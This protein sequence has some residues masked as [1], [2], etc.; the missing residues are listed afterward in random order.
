MR[1]IFDIPYVDGGAVAQRLDMYL[2][3]GEG[4]PTL[5]FFHGG[6]FEKCDKGGKEF[7]VLAEYFNSVGIG[8]ISANYRMYPDG[9]RFPDYI[10]DGAAAVAWAK[11]HISEYGGSGEL[12]VGGSSAGGHMSMLLCYDKK[13]LGAY[14]ID[15]MDIKAYIHDAGQ[16]TVHFNVLREDGLPRYSCRVDQRAP[17][18]HVGAAKEYAPQQIFVADNDIKCRYEETMLLYRSFEALGYDMSKIRL[19]YMQG[20]KHTQYL[21]MVDDSGV[22]IFRQRVYK[23]LS[24]LKIV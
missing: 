5:V 22:S 3:E 20:Y 19:E 14:G 21:G 24:D 9:A 23:F 6:G 2:P 10:E 12:F 16:P 15:P 7:P 4:F 13:Y 18:Y 8:L 17:I 11:A 1:K